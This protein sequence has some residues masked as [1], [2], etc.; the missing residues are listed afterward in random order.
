M[1]WLEIPGTGFTVYA[2]AWRTV[3]N[4]MPLHC[5]RKRTAENIRSNFYNAFLVNNFAH[6]TRLS[7]MRPR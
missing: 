6:Q 1:E 2:L 7:T 4:R 5:N 3:F